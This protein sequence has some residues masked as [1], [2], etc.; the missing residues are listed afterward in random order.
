MRRFAG[1]GDLAETCHSGAQASSTMQETMRTDRQA[2]LMKVACAC[3][4][5]VF[6]V[7]GSKLYEWEYWPWHNAAFMIAVV[8]GS[9]WFVL[10]EK[11]LSR[12]RGRWM[13]VRAGVFV[14]ALPWVL[15]MMAR[16]RDG[17]LIDVRSGNVAV[18]AMIFAIGALIVHR[19]YSLRAH[20]LRD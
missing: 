3:A 15:V 2:K 6:V 17:G 19:A 10:R 20:Q 16:P 18:F 1:P 11:D 13:A 5:P 9:V 8:C 7:L 14:G 12:Y 4:F